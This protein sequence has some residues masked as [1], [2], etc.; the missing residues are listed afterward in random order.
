MLEL[1]LDD[2]LLLERYR[3][4]RVLGKGGF[5]TTYAAVDEHSGREV[6]IKQLDLS[7]VDDWK[8]VELFEREARTLEQLSHERIPEYIDFVP[9]EAEAS[10]FLIQSL[11]P[12]RSLKDILDDH[13]TFTDQQV[14]AIAE[15]T[16]EILQ[17]LASL[18]PPVVHRDIKPANL[19]LDETEEVYLVDFGAVQDA[20]TRSAD[21]GSTVAGT[22]GYM[23]PEQLHGV[24]TPA[25]DLFGLGMTLIHLAS[26]I[27]PTSLGRDGLKIDFHDVVDLPAEFMEFIDRLVE[28]NPDDRF[29]DPSTALA[30]LHA[31]VPVSG[32]VS[33]LLDAD[34]LARMVERREAARRQKSEQRERERRERAAAMKSTVTVES[35]DDGVVLT[36]D[37]PF[38]LRSCL[39]PILI[40]GFLIINP[41]VFLAH[42]DFVGSFWPIIGSE[43]LEHTAIRWSIWGGFV[44]F[45]TA[46]IIWIIED[47][48]IRL[49]LT[50][51]HY[52]FYRDDPE[53]P[54]ATGRREHLR[55]DVK[56]DHG[57]RPYGTV[58]FFAFQPN[59]SPLLNRT[60]Q[61]VPLQ[62]LEVVEEICKPEWK[63]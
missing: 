3:V 39:I 21:G 24:A 4:T 17:Y 47:K 48:K 58:R 59:G 8:A 29:A 55:V 41:G 37:P 2:A 9:V 23:A 22:F 30:F 54:L 20:A 35:A 7:L 33:G 36:V 51:A 25:S 26:G 15:Q 28:P 44:L 53:S 52:L 12:G 57:G 60:Y 42:P 40:A 32:S 6:A 63:R 5:G 56:P 45:I 46:A 27:D 34:S 50:D 38:R 14:E 62:D 19:L 16:L 61:R 43:N 1:Q 10:G 31:E 11:A 13:G 49:W 18:N